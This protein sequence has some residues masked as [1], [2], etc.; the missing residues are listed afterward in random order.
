L[1]ADERLGANIHLWRN[2]TLQSTG[3]RN[4]GRMAKIKGSN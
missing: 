2:G 3:T 1:E 4:L